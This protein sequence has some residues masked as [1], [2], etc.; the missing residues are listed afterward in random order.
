MAPNGRVT[1]ED[2]GGPLHTSRI[3]DGQIEP[4]PLHVIHHHIPSVWFTMA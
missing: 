3:R 2:A 4:A 1:R